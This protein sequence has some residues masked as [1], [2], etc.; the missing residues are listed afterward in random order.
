LQDL[1]DIQR[2]TADSSQLKCIFLSLNMHF[3]NPSINLFWIF[4]FLHWI[5]ACI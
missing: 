2:I 3:L 1:V 5:H 4:G